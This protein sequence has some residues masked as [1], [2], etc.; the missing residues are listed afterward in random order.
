MPGDKNGRLSFRAAL[1]R[2][3]HVDIVCGA[4]TRCISDSVMIWW[5]QLTFVTNTVSA[6][7]AMIAPG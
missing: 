2:L 1:C 6:Y 7:K 4:S 5:S 3:H